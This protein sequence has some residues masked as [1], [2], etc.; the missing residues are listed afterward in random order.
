MAFIHGW[1]AFTI[2]SAHDT[3]ALQDE[4]GGHLHNAVSA[5][6]SPAMENDE[7][8]QFFHKLED[9]WVDTFSV[10]GHVTCLGPT[11]LHQKGGRATQYSLDYLIEAPM[12]EINR[13]AEQLNVA[14]LGPG[15]GCPVCRGGATEAEKENWI[16]EA[17]RRPRKTS[18][19]ST[20]TTKD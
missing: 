13:I 16:G 3:I 19:D 14:V 15:Q 1:K 8:F 7:G 4:E 18:N 5:E 6:A 10:Y 2:V 9:A 12:T 11:V 17:Y 20:G